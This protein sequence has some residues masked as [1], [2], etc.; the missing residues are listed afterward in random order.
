MAGIN[1]VGKA[2]VVVG[3]DTKKA[4][5]DIERFRKRLEQT[6][7]GY[8]KLFKEDITR[9]F[10][11]NFRKGFEQGVL[12]GVQKGENQFYQL[13]RAINVAAT[14]LQK[15]KG[16]AEMAADRFMKLQRTGL[17]MQAAFGTIAGT[18]G[19]LAGGILG[20]VGV[21]GAAAPAA[22]AL[23]GA[24][25]SV[26]VGFVG[27]KVAMSG[28]SNAIGA[29]WQSQ[30]ALN[31]T[32]RAAT[33]EYIGL[34]FAAEEAALSQEDAALKLEVAREA[35]ARVQDLP[36]D[37]RLRRQTELA[38]KNA[39]LNLRETKHK[40]EEAF[41]AVKKG[42]TA[43][44]AYQP[45]AALSDVQL[46]FVK[47]VVALRPQMQTLKK[48]VAAGFIPKLTESINTIMKHGFPIF[49]TG[50][51]Q[52]ASAMGDATKTFASA[53]KNPQNL[54]Q[55]AGFFKSSTGI[56]HSFGSA[57]KSSFGILITLLHAAEPITK[58]FADWVDK[59]LAG[60]DK[61]VKVG[62]F[63]G[64]LQR[65]FALAGDVS[66]R[67]GKAFSTVFD[68]IKN[69]IKATFPSGPK[70]GA[71]GVLLDF[72][73]KVTQGFEKFTGSKS[74]ASWLENS[75]KGAVAALTT[76]GK[77]LG[78]F[79]DLAGSKDTKAF[80]DTIQQAIPYVKTILEN[81]QAV[82]VQIA[83]ILVDVA[84]ILA[85]FADQGTL[86]TFFNSLR[87]IF[88]AFANF[89]NSPIVKTI[90]GFLGALHGP[91][92]AL[93]AV[94]ILGKKALEI[95]LGYLAKA[96][97]IMGTTTMK[98]RAAQQAHQAFGREMKL[99]GLA[100]E[101]FW[102]KLR[103]ASATANNQKLLAMGREAGFAKD[104]LAQLELQMIS[105]SRTATLFDET[106]QK[107]T[108]LME[109]D[110]NQALELALRIEQLAK[111]QGM[112]SVALNKL[113]TQMLENIT[114]AGQENITNQ[115]LL[116]GTELANGAYKAPFVNANEAAYY[117]QPGTKG[118]NP[119][120][121]LTG[122][123]AGFKAVGA[124]IKGM[125]GGMGGGGVAG[126]LGMGA[127]AV[128]GLVGMGTGTMGPIGMA[129]QAIGGIASM[130]GPGGMVVGGLLSVGGT[131]V[132]GIIAAENERQKGIKE[133]RIAV[134]NMSVES[135]NQVQGFAEK[136][137][138]AGYVGTKAEGSALA[139][140]Y[141]ATASRVI[142]STTHE[143]RATYSK[144][145]TKQA[146][147]MDEALAAFALSNKRAFQLSQRN[148]NQENILNSVGSIAQH[149]TLSTTD[150]AGALGSLSS[151]TE[152]TKDGV[153]QG[154]VGAG[155]VGKGNLTDLKKD[156]GYTDKGVLTN[157]SFN[158]LLTDIKNINKSTPTTPGVTPPP[159][160]L[161]TAV[162]PNKFIPLGSVQP[163]PNIYD[164][165]TIYGTN[166][167]TAA[168]SQAARNFKLAPATSGL[169]PDA[170]GDLSTQSFFKLD[171]NKNVTGFKSQEGQNQVTNAI[172]D[173][174]YALSGIRGS[175]TNESRGYYKY[176]G[177]I[178]SPSELEKLKTK[179]PT[180]Y[181][182]IKKD[183]DAFQQEQGYNVS[184]KFF[185]TELFNSALK[186]IKVK[187]NGK[188]LNAYDALAGT[189]TL[190]N[191]GKIGE[192]TST[193]K[194][195]N[196]ILDA[197][198]KTDS[199]QLKTFT[200]ASDTMKTSA[201]SWGKAAAKF[202]GY[203]DLIKGETNKAIAF[204]VVAASTEGKKAIAAGDTGAINNLI[205]TEIKKLR[206][207]TK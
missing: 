115:G 59:Y 99:A 36:P 27:V 51:K 79:V 164:Y 34:K 41:R 114:L 67:L 198:N 195:G 151:I 46:Q 113:N 176:A 172:S 74:F 10:S 162:A 186:S 82:G 86:V 42:I 87:V 185:S 75:T 17:K 174:S 178:Y 183:P 80:W 158:K 152:D 96:A 102:Q 171:A 153:L 173:L 134:A 145:A 143:I 19:D 26:G 66:A 126:G 25:A 131:I 196:P 161:P 84:K 90:L 38:F 148:V 85:A 129:T 118:G 2:N 48:E 163:N 201:E 76:I 157:E 56:I 71:G 65:M 182:A 133:F 154:L 30:T 61:K 147:A 58:R 63:T 69:I 44:S 106:T 193:G 14:S 5:I 130:F 24:M 40:S 142:P 107:S 20:L 197:A 4:E 89:V 3:A 139:S 181:N 68:G 180:R 132:D 72:I 175:I 83:G 138:A 177:N 121:V 16:P 98:A 203:G 156:L 119:N 125:F 167:Y 194:T 109:M 112:D 150:I 8:D 160:S 137:V 108:N 62:S 187:I 52:V 77:F 207:S 97:N 122:G 103:R 31:D 191:I 204:A 165:K 93:G 57:T 47:F 179:N 33:Q 146:A 184:G 15:I 54:Q 100:G 111:A 127:M 6:G 206:L 12:R 60:L 110:A 155:L 200:T 92:L 94:F 88:D 190:A 53:F 35:L 188:D 168:Q 28:V 140:K 64:S 159:G 21:L 123:R 124:G 199:E 170:I 23:G 81:G 73:D 120:L 116:R 49:K 169:L 135:L 70:S 55:L 45:L 78:I 101:T 104:R 9:K 7:R 43:T 11:E 18:I 39:E 117:G 32:F 192:L 91:M 22:V 50:L 202:E 29:V 128:S 144:D 149:S 95:F 166:G 189:T 141:D 205:L 136:A 105:N 13:N 37:N 1:E